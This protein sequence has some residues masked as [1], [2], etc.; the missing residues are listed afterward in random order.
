MMQVVQVVQM[1]GGDTDTVGGQMTVDP[2]VGTLAV[3]SCASCVTTNVAKGSSSSF[4]EGTL[5][6][7]TLLNAAAASSDVGDWK[8]TGVAIS[9][10]IPSE[11]GAASDYDIN[12]V[13]SIV[14][15]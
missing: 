3:G 9:Q 12:M 1:D 6:S 13:V 10:K 7:I 8:F 11:Q 2:S 14:A 15:Q 5:D 4:A